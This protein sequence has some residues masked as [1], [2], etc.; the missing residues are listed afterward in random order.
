MSLHHTTVV[1]QVVQHLR[2]GGIETMVLSLLKHQPFKTI[3]FSL[4]GTKE[5]AIQR[6]PVLEQVRDQIVF[7]NKPSGLSWLT[8]YRLCLLF[9]KY[10]VCA[11]HSHHIGPLVYG[12]IA[13]KFI[14]I[15]KHVHTEHDAWHLINIKH[16]ILQKFLLLLVK[17]T[18]VADALAVANKIKF[19]LNHH[20]VTLIYNGIDTTKFIPG[21]RNSARHHLKLPTGVVLIGNA[22]R[23]EVVKGQDVLINA[24]SQFSS[25]IHLAIAGD[26]SCADLL[27]AQA[28]KLNIEHQIHFLGQLDDMTNFYQS[29]DI[30]CLP[31][32]QEGL[33]LSPM[34]AQ[35]C[36]I[37]TLVTN[38]G[39]SAEALCQTTGLLIEQDNVE[40]LVNAIETMISRSTTVTPRQ[41]IAQHR[42]IQ[43]MANAYAKLISP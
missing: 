19:Y 18:V 9:K 16:R 24:I 12:G 39:G 36:G 27:K 17:P 32:R 37:P 35:A 26:G 6:W 22:A 23:L 20:D 31:S 25:S 5:E 8:V 15:T 40:Q 2:P 41:F 38:V 10:H 14:G 42:N 1:A 29:L 13:A 30:F 34:E 4:E 43:G 21:N 28:V 7:L 3:I 11:L 33:P